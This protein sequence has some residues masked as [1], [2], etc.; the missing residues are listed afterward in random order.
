MN[1]TTSVVTL[2]SKNKEKVEGVIKAEYGKDTLDNLTQIKILENTLK[3]ATSS[4][5]NEA[6]IKSS[7]NLSKKSNEAESILIDIYGY[8]GGDFMAEIPGNI[9]VEVGSQVYLAEDE[10]KLLGEVVKVEKKDASY[11]QRLLIRGYY[12]TRINNTY[13]IESN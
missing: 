2:F 1:L 4:E 13:Y 11:Y 12:N 3:Q 5:N 8:G 9:K 10:S 6:E 7:S